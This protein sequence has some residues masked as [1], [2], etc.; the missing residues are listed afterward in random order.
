MI[1]LPTDAVSDQS[2]S[3]YAVDGLCEMTPAAGATNS[4]NITFLTDG[5]NA[6]RVHT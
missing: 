6:G 2:Y 4:P 1:S 5:P 3:P